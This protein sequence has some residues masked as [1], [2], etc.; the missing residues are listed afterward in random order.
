[1]ADLIRKQKLLDDFDRMGRTVRMKLL[2]RYYYS[3]KSIW[4]ITAQA[5]QE[6]AALIPQIPY[7]GEKN[8]WQLNLDACAMDLALYRALKK[9]GFTFTEAVQMMYDIFEAYLQSFPRPMRLAYRW[10]YFSPFYQ[11]YL[12]RGAALS[13]LR[14]YPEDWVFTYVGG[15]GSVFDIGVDITECAIVKFCYA[16]GAEHLVACL[17][18]LDHAMGKL[19]GL[20]LAR[21]GTLAE[22]APVC[23]CRWKYGAETP[24]WPTSIASVPIQKLA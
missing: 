19:L 5:R 10:Y 11:H 18:K 24:D 9:Q 1:M 2:D 4:N 3:A 22:G 15:D 8:I 20:G 7:I 6:F 21:T 17:C 16:Q 13:Q 12:R 23:D 14:R